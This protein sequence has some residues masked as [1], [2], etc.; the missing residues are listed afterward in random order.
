MDGGIPRQLRV[1]RNTQHIPLANT[2]YL[3][4]VPSCNDNIFTNTRN[5]RRPN[6]SRPHRPHPASRIPPIQNSLSR[7]NLRPKSIPPHRHI[8]H[9]Q[10]PLARRWIINLPRQHNQPRTR[11]QGR[12]AVCYSLNKRLTHTQNTGQTINRRRLTTWQH[13]SI[14]PNEV[15][16]LP[17]KDNARTQ[18]LQHSHMLSNTT[19][20]S[21]NTDSRGRRKT[22]HKKASKLCNYKI[23]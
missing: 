14:K 18:P 1:E 12:Q 2:H 16:S 10:R 20:K 4:P 5:T 8:Q 15:L 3:A 23:F 17:H 22:S 21:Q 6:K 9:P 13:Q 11:T 7:I 19:L